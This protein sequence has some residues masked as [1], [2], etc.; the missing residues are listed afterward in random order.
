M[1]E[2]WRIVEMYDA[3]TAMPEEH[4]AGLIVWVQDSIE[5]TLGS[6]KARFEG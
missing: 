3:L 6:L 4:Q 5:Q 2:T 1:E